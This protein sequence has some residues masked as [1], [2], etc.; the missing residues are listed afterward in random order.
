MTVLGPNDKAPAHEEE[1]EQ[2]DEQDGADL[3][4]MV[5]LPPS[6]A[7][8]EHALEISVFRAEALPKM[9]TSII[10]NHLKLISQNSGQM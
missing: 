7:T 10:F 5:L 2:D 3:Q 8:E 9:D 1:E 4:S 6:I